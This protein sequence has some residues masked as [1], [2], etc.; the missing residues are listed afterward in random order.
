MTAAKKPPP[1]RLAQRRDELVS[2]LRPALRMVSKGG[3]R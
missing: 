1:M 3:G 2:D